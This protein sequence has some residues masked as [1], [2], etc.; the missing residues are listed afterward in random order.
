MSANQ[1]VEWLKTVLVPLERAVDYH[2]DKMASLGFQRAKDRQSPDTSDDE[3]SVVIDARETAARRLLKQLSTL[4]TFARSHC[5]ATLAE[6]DAFSN[7][8]KKKDRDRFAQ[9]LAAIRGFLARD[10]R[11]QRYGISLNELDLSSFQDKPTVESLC[12]RLQRGVERETEYALRAYLEQWVGR[13][14]R[15]R[16][17][18]DIGPIVY[19]A[20]DR[21]LTLA[22]ADDIYR[23]YVEHRLRDADSADESEEIDDLLELQSEFLAT[24]PSRSN[25]PELSESDIDPAILPDKRRLSENAHLC[26]STCATVPG[27]RKPICLTKPYSYYGQ[28]YDWDYCEK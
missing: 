27:Y 14:G 6:R 23:L 4:R 20:L 12:Q 13:G 17:S 1:Y 18:Y 9:Q 11:A 5:N 28:K 19:F 21:D 7:S 3:S 25:S 24:S 8:D 16:R 26:E 15:E 22:S 10:A 2:A